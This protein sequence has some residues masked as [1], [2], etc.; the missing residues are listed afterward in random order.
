MKYHQKLAKWRRERNLKLAYNAL[1][2]WGLALGLC[3]G[4]LA[5]IVY[6]QL[7]IQGNIIFPDEWNI[8]ELVMSCIVTFVILAAFVAHFIKMFRR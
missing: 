2:Y 5:I 4:T 3:A 1:V 7:G 6:Y 8:T